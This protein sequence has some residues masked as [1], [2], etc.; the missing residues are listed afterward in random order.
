[1]ARRKI[2]AHLLDMVKEGQRQAEAYLTRA[3][4]TG[5][6]AIDGA[7]ITP[8]TGWSVLLQRLR[9]NASGLTYLS[10]QVQAG[11]TATA[12]NVVT[13]SAGHRPATA[14]VAL[15]SF[16]VAGSGHNPAALATTGVVVLAN[17]PVNGDVVDLSGTYVSEQ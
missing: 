6:L 3:L 2:A 13:L 9:K 10:I 14:G 12:A 16:P 15:A 7:G 4:A 8:G 1:M 5:I 17:A 11:A